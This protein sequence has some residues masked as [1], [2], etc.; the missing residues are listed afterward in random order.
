[1]VLH[2]QQVTVEEFDAWVLLPQ[3]ADM[4]FENIRGEI[5]EV[6]SNPY[7]SKISSRIS[8]YIFMYLLQ[9][10]I[11]HLTGEQGGYQVAGERYAPDVAFTTYHSQPEEVARQGYNPVPPDL[12]VEV[13]SPTD[14][15]EFLRVKVANYLFAGTEV[16]LVDPDTQRVEVYA[17]AKK[18]RFIGADAVLETDLL[19]GFSLAVKDI[20]PQEKSDE[21]E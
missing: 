7:S 16:W 11:G 6:P 18:M 14:S 13:M 20:F 3:N 4:L 21:H 2:K 12:A 10:D 19:P 9:N 8:G 17:P 1:M 5:V 15:D